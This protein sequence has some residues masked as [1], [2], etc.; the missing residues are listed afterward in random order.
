MT[1]EDARS[2]TELIADDFGAY[3]DNSLVETFLTGMQEFLDCPARVR[4]LHITISK[5]S[6]IIFMTL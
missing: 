2:A 6:A 3:P 1:V 4:A 5:L